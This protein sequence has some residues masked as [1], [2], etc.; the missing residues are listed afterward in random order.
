[1]EL[2]QQLSKQQAPVAYQRL[3]ALLKP[4]RKAPVPTA[5]ERGARGLGG[6]ARH[7][8]SP[9]QGASGAFVGSALGVEWGAYM[10]AA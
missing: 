4:G 2:E 10:V 1:M 7:A 8:S 3:S 9:E 6:G 5:G